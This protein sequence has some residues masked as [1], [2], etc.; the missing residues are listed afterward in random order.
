MDKQFARIL[1]LS[2][3]LPAGA[4][5]GEA[6]QHEHVNFT[7][8]DQSVMSQLAGASRA[9]LVRKTATEDREAITMV[10]SRQN[11]RAEHRA[12]RNA[13]ESGAAR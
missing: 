2:I 8:L 13:S 10:A 5:L 9:D 4:A 11:H 1:M 6:I 3:L 12:L 7:A